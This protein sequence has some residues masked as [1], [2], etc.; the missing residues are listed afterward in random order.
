MTTETKK[1]PEIVNLPAF[2]AGY[3]AFFNGSRKPYT[4]SKRLHEEAILMSHTRE[5]RKAALVKWYAERGIIL[6][7]GK[8]EYR[9]EQVTQPDCPYKPHTYAAK[10]WQ[11][12]FNAAFHKN[13][14]RNTNARHAGP[15]HPSR[16]GRKH[17]EG[18][19]SARKPK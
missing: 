14:E 19:S 9:A 3:G 15:A 7:L 12:G 5:K 8:G 16:G 10:E 11:R 6:T 13:S 1:Y 2:N 17:R 4:L 18:H